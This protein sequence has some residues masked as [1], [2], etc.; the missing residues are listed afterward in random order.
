VKNA[1]GTSGRLP[2]SKKLFLDFEAGLHEFI[3]DPAMGI[4]FLGFAIG[5][6]HNH[7]DVIL[8]HPD[9]TP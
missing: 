1:S 3:M 2:P 5:V 9:L 7:V 6:S 8:A 4:P